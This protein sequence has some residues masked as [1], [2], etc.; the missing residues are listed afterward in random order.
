[1]RQCNRIDPAPHWAARQRYYDQKGRA[2]YRGIEWR[3]T[4]EEWYQWWR[5]QGIDRNLPLNANSG[6][7]LCMCRFK[8]EGPYSLENIYC[9]TRSENSK[10]RNQTRPN[11]GW[12]GITG[13]NHPR[14]GYKIGETKQQKMERENK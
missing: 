7:G 5:D 1:M 2:G 12:T 13:S 8:D 9:G 4:F 11:S 10:E 3:L 6:Q 14:Y